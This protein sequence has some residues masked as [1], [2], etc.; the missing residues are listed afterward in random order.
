MSVDGF[1]FPAEGIICIIDDLWLQSHHELLRAASL[2]PCG[3]SL[4]TE[5]SS[6]RRGPVTGTGDFVIRSSSKFSVL[7]GVIWM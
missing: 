7:S 1:F 4:R 5:P 6:D 3:A 2:Y